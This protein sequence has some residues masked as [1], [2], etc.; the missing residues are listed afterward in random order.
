MSHIRGIVVRLRTK[1]QSNAGTDDHIYIGVVGK[2]GGREFPLDVRGFDDF[3][4]GSDVKYWFGTV[5]DGSL[6]SG[7]RKPYRSETG[8]IND[9]AWFRMELDEIDYVYVKKQGNNTTAGDDAWKMDSIEV[10]L[11]G[12][13]P[14]RRTFSTANDLWFANEFGR[15]VWL[16]EVIRRSLISK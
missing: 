9:P 15:Q 4:E 1:N 5:W 12:A 16:T 3:E 14:Q 7:A 2:G 11:F 6:L 13:S 10:S 8:N